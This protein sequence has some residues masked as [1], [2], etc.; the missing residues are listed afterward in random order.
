MIGGFLFGLT[1]DKNEIWNAPGERR[2]L[3]NVSSNL[4]DSFTIGW[5]ADS[6]NFFISGR[7][8]GDK[9]LISARIF[10]FSGEMLLELID[11]ELTRQSPRMYQRIGLHDGWKVCDENNH[12]LIHILIEQ[13]RVSVVGEFYDN[14]GKI[15]AKGDNA[16]G[17]SLYCPFTLG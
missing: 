2:K 1:M 8:D 16:K 7:F 5:P 3:F 12:D 10:G 6:A 15:A 4:I 17:L 11:S 13:N 9:P 14:S